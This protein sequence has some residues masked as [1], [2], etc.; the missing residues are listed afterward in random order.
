[1][2]GE[3]TKDEN[4]PV[5]AGVNHWGGE[6]LR[7]ANC[8]YPAVAY[9]GGS[10]STVILDMINRSFDDYVVFTMYYVKELEFYKRMMDYV[11]LRYNKD[12]LLVP[13]YE[14]PLLINNSNYTRTKIDDMPLLK[15][16]DICDYVRNT[17]G[18][19]WV[20]WGIK[21]VDSVIR[22][23]MLKKDGAINRKSRLIMPLS[24]CTNKDIQG[25][26]R[27]NR[28][29]TFTTGNSIDIMSNK[30]NGL[31]FLS[32]KDM[33]KIKKVFPLIEIKRARLEKFGKLQDSN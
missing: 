18:A 24:D 9:S 31:A 27:Y 30:K 5:V 32:P 12:V 28:L 1:M 7:D 20:L 2:L 16:T 3:T 8:R 11:K 14:L 15:F 29:R 6:W 4:Q 26:I 33:A 25:Y 23:A 19:D 13:H 21:K 10:D 17:T 22:G